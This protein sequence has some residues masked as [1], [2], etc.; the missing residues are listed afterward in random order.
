MPHPAATRRSDLFTQMA[1]VA[2]AVTC[3]AFAGYKVM[4]L[5][6][7][8]TPPPDMGL[9]FPAP[10]RRVITDDSVLVDDLTTG[11]IGPV[12]EESAPPP[13]PLQP[14][15]SEAPLQDYRLIQVINGMAF[16]EVRTLRGKEV[17]TLTAGSHLPGAGAVT[18]ISRI[19]GRWTL[20]A[21]DVTLV[22]QLQ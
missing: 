1:A 19:G 15:T 9:N 21:G 20:V 8:E 14:Y 17:R 16:V 3:A 7:I 12:A 10:K 4:K 13:R 5:N 2:L 6:G 11:S 18:R 22:Q